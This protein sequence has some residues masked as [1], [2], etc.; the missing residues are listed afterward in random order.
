M[1]LST[2]WYI[3]VLL[4]MGVFSVTGAVVCLGLYFVANNEYNRIIYL[5]G[6]FVSLVSAFFSLGMSKI[7]LLFL[8]INSHK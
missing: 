5:A 8:N 3:P 4:T 6:F 1:Q 2:P 7:S